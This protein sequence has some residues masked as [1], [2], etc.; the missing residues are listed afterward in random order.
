MKMGIWYYI[1][2]YFQKSQKAT[3]DMT[4]KRILIGN[5]KLGLTFEEV[6]FISLFNATGRKSL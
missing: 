3:L 6:I 5:S 1:K 2:D 4:T